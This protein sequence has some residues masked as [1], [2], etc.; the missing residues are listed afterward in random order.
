MLDLS[1]PGGELMFTVLFQARFHFIPVDFWRF[2][3]GLELI[4]AEAEFSDVQ[5]RFSSAFRG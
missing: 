4:L 3:S 5:K 2:T 1:R